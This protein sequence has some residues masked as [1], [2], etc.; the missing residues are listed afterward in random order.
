M[1]IYIDARMLKCAGIGTYLKNILP[2]LRGFPITLLVRKKDTNAFPWLN[3]FKI[4]IFDH[5]IYS[6]QEQ[7][8]YQRAL[9]RC[10]LFWS[11]HINVPY[12]SIQ[13]KKRLVTIHDVY[14]L[15]FFSKLKFKEKLYAKKIY[16]K[17]VQ[18]SDW[19]ITDSK[20]SKEELIRYTKAKKEKIQTIYCGVDSD[21]FK[22]KDEESIAKINQ[23]Y[24]LDFPYF[25]FVGNLK[26]H[27]NLKRVFEAIK[28]I[29]N[30]YHLIIIGKAEGLLNKMDIPSLLE[31]TELR[32][33][34]HIFSE[35][36]D[37]ELPMFYQGAIATIFPSFYEGFGLPVLEAMSC[38]CPVLGSH[39]ASIPEVGG[40]A[41]CYF[42]PFSI[43]EI[44][45][46]IDKINT[47]DRYRKEL[48]QKGYERIKQFSWEES[49]MAHRKVIERLLE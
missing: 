15:A 18:S 41:L 16:Q 26:P 46:S 42:D 17:A 22:K 11:P 10:A 14:H 32:N 1:S 45:Q 35:V 2:Y 33:R 27:K 24:H 5:P 12:F 40:E 38:G 29:S 21:F 19:I 28:K 6:I 4:Q 34:V 9:G 47:D 37:E 7:I 31:S 49:A 20:F 13:A 36:Q 23:K 8:Y 3:S 43:D 48:I 39:A 25:L 30:R 44:K